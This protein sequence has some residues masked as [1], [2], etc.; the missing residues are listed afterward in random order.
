MPHTIL[1]TGANGYIGQHVIKKLL[2]LCPDDTVVA[3]DLKNDNIDR[4]AVY[5]S[6][7]ILREAGSPNLYDRL[8]RPD[9]CIHLAWQ[10]GF[11]HNAESHIKNLP[12]HFAFLKNM[13]DSGCSSVSVMGTMHEIGCYEGCVD[14]KTPCNPLSFYGIAKNALRQSLFAYGQGKKTNLKWLRAFYITGD[15]LHN[16]SIFSKIL[17]L[18]KEGKKSFPFT[19]GTNKYDFTDIDVL[20][21]QI[22]S[23]SVQN[24]VCGIIN[25]CSGHAVPLREKV[26]EFL[27]RNHLKI[28]PEYGA[29]P[30]RSYD[31]PAIWGDNGKISDILGGGAN[32]DY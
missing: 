26:E 24:K 23:A 21:G 31:S 5:V 3:A 7:D 17:E 25:V 32:A 14:E 15:D 10:D 28:R 4:Q 12:A 30:D 20:A 8:R 13:I 29:Y 2:L 27:S 18:E 1:V 16:K 22:A 6:P 9:V 11:N 19:S